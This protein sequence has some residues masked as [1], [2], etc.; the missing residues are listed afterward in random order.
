M[1]TDSGSLVKSLICSFTDSHLLLAKF[2]G[3]DTQ[4]NGTVWQ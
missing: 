3:K 1:K 2:D 4:A